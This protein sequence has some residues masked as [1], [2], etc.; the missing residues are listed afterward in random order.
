MRTLTIPKY[1]FKYT[2]LPDVEEDISKKSLV[3]AIRPIFHNQSY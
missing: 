2:P 3:V 1:Q